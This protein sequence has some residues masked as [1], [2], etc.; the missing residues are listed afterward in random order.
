[1]SA[2]SERFEKLDLQAGILDFSVG[3]ASYKRSLQ[4]IHM[5]L[6]HI[7]HCKMLS[8]HSFEKVYE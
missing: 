8:H 4:V 2:H 6:S 7:V 1:M 5:S 3:I